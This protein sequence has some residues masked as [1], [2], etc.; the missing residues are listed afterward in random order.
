M[1]EDLDEEEKLHEA[2]YKNNTMRYQ[3][4]KR[5]MLESFASDRR[6]LAASSITNPILCIVE[7]QAIQFPVDTAS[8]VY[9]VYQ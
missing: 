6:H 4:D 1:L 7:G 2:F 3:T 8:R 5:R 9:P